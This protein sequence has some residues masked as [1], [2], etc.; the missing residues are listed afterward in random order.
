MYGLKCLIHS[1]QQLT[2]VQMLGAFV[3]ALAAADTGGG[4]HFES[5]IVGIGGVAF[6]V[7]LL[8]IED[9]KQVGDL[10]AGGA[11]LH[12]VAAVGAGASALA[13][14]CLL[15]SSGSPL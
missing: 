10:D 14:I 9:G 5:G 6:L 1:F 8:L 3:F 13:R 2:D 11:A 7:P 15:I 12:A 4:L